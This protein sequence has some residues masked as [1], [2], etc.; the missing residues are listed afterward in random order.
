MRSRSAGEA[1]AGTARSRNAGRRGCAGS[2]GR[3]IIPSSSIQIPL[4][5]LTMPNK[6]S[7][8]CAAS[9]S[10]GCSAAAFAIH[11]PAVS[12]PRAS[13]ATVTISS[14]CGLSSVRSSCH[15][16]RSRRQPHHDAHA[17]S[18][19]FVPRSDDKRNDP[20]RKSGSSSSGA[21]ALRSARPPA[22]APSAHRPWTCVV[23]ERHRESLRRG[24]ELDCGRDRR[25]RNG[26]QRSPRHRPSG[27]ASHPV[28]RS[29]SATGTIELVKITTRYGN[30]MRLFIVALIVA[31]ACAPVT[32]VT[33][34]P[35][36]TIT[37]TDT[38]SPTRVADAS[39]TRRRLPH[40][41]RAS[42]RSFDAHLHYS[43]A[44]VVRL[45]ARG[46]REAPRFGRRSLRT[47]IERARRRHLQAARGPGRSRHPDAWCVPKRG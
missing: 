21:I 13:S 35:S 28:T 18:S 20:P 6:A 33:P 14:P 7:T 1:S 38:P 29:N 4:G 5:T 39:P 36:P 40:R 22:S 16:G 8:T 43:S 12:L 23:N 2:G 11:G 46:G 32:T 44:G 42:C 17:T 15:T 19:T 24:S 25:Q 41:R 26:T 9:M 30:S 37:A 10:E 3:T 31:S 34:S 47:R 27:F 45:S